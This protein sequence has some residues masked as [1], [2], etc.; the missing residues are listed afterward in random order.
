[1]ICYGNVSDKSTYTWKTGLELYDDE[2]TF[3]SGS[4]SGFNHQYQVIAI[5]DDNSEEPDGN[6]NPIINPANDK[7]GAN[8]MAEGDT[9]KY[10]AAGVMVQLTVAEWK[11]IRAAVN[12]G[13]AIPIDAATNG[14]K[15]ISGAPIW[16]MRGT[17]GMRHHCHA[18]SKNL[19]VAHLNMRH[20]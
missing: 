5:I 3:F 14:K 1:M 10:V 8:H 6:N 15:A 17:Y 19:S 7:R 13:V 18:T 9:A 4:S 11:T 12:N 2:Q 16:T 20:A